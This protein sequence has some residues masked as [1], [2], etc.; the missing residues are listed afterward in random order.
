MTIMPWVRQALTC[1]TVPSHTWHWYSLMATKEM[2][3]TRTSHWPPREHEG[4]SSHCEPCLV[5]WRPGASTALV[6]PCWHRWHLFLCRLLLAG[7]HQPFVL[8]GLH[9]DLNRIKPSHSYSLQSHHHPAVQC[10]RPECV[11]TLT[12][13]EIDGKTTMGCRWW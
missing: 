10:Y 1:G 8:R 5:V 12:I 3:Y 2:I 11:G 9:G 7:W 4:S 13:T 6:P